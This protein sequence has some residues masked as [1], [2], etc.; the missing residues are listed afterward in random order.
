MSPNHET[1]LILITLGA[2]L[3]I[4]LFTDALGKYT[5]LPRVTLLILFGVIIGPSCLNAIPTRVINAFPLLTNVALS[6]IGFLIGGQLKW[7]KMKSQGKA[8]LSI[9]ISE[10]VFTALIVCAGFAIAGMPLAV[11][12]L[13]AGI[14]CST[15]P[16]TT[17][18]VVAEG[19]SKG[20]FTDALV[21]IVAIDDVWA[22]IAFGLFMAL[23]QQ[24]IG[25]NDTHFALTLS[26]D[27]GGALI[28]GVLLGIPAAL[29]SGR[30][31][32]GEPTL[33][34]ALGVVLLSCG[35]SNLFDL[36]FILTSITLGVTVV[37]L[38]RHHTSAFHEIENIERP[39]MVL[40][41]ILAG[42]S[43]HLDMIWASGW[44]AIFYILFRI[45]GRI[46]G[47]WIGGRIVSAEPVI[48]KW[49]G[50]AL[51]PQA[52]VSLG[53][54]LLSSQTL[55]EIGQMIL[56]AT[57]GAT[58]FFEIAGPMMTRLALVKAGEHQLLNH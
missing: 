24:M 8:V 50:F 27:I 14:S 58:V 17:L 23:A 35:L 7:S 39:F 9:S 20:K 51:M 31:S 25:I 4:G 32:P 57:L 11:A 13:F 37:N 45:I 33:L 46:A 16:A 36:S 49:M 41:F 53:M 19:Q 43:L 38:A 44:I 42:V 56:P 5:R 3:L 15:D 54:A 6:M 55:P 30:I 40:F 26:W 28:L 2:L 29:L 34:E 10:V 12:M 48:S 21:Q 1:A 52:G 18:D 47:A 22:I